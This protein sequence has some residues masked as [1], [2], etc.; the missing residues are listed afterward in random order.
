MNMMRKMK[1]RNHKKWGS[2]DGNKSRKRKI[3]IKKVR[4]DMNRNKK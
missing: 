2:K 1:K 4:I 3:L